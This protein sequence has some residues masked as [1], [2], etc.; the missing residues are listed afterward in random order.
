MPF[1][2]TSNFRQDDEFQDLQ[3][4]FNV[5]LDAYREV[6]SLPLLSARQYDDTL[7]RPH[8]L[9]ALGIDYIADVQRGT[10]TALKDAPNLQAAFFSLLEGKKVSPAIAAKV[11]TRCGRI[12]K[13]RGLSPGRYFAPRERKGNTDSLSLRRAA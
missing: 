6:L 12:Y 3:L 2:Q 11:I 1:S 9:N 4:I 5:T 7:P 10:T 8:V 13:Q